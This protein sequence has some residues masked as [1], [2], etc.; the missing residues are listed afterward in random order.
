M[1]VG[2]AEVISGWMSPKLKGL[3]P[4]EL[5]P[6][7]LIA[8]QTEAAG[9]MLSGVVVELAELSVQNGVFPLELIVLGPWGLLRS[10][11]GLGGGVFLGV[12]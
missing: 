8:L 5:F 1:R 10:S 11:R 3:E 2:L 6:S 9:G 7:E 12:T 4:A